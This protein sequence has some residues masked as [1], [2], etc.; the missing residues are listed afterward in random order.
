MTSADLSRRVE[1]VVGDPPLSEMS[2]DQRREFHEALFDADAFEDLH[3]KWQA[4]IPHGRSEPAEAPRRSSRLRLENPAACRGTTV[5][6]S[7]ALSGPVPADRQAKRE[8]RRSPRPRRSAIPSFE[9]RRGRQEHGELGE[10]PL[11]PGFALA[12]ASQHRT[13]PLGEQQRPGVDE[14][15]P[16]ACEGGLASPRSALAMGR[17]ETFAPRSGFTGIYEP[18]EDSAS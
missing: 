12:A 16:S 5:A 8:G 9:L 4:A 6:V 10:A 11:R 18:Q 14:N 17:A 7:R 3:G 13:N 2:D 15:P 1:K